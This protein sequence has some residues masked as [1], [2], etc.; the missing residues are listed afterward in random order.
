MNN[1]FISANQGGFEKLQYLDLDLESDTNGASGHASF[2][3]PRSPDSL[4]VYHQVDFI[5][6]EAFMKTRRV[7]EEERKQCSVEP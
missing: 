7:V 4:T 2:T 1:E 6:T 5:K 3:V